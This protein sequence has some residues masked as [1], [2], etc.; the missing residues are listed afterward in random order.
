MKAAFDVANLCCSNIS[1]DPSQLLTHFALFTY[2]N[3][4]KLKLVS[5]KQKDNTDIFNHSVSM[6]AKKKKS[7]IQQTFILPVPQQCPAGKGHSLA[8]RLGADWGY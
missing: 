5:E 8:A 6:L 3:V 2:S 4:L 1:K 7:L